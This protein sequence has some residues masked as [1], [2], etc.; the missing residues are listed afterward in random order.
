MTSTFMRITVEGYKFM[1]E[2]LSTKR[3]PKFLIILITEVD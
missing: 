2:A 3:Y 1:M